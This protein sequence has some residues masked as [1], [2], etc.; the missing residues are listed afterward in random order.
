MEAVV[1]SRVSLKVS[2]VDSLDKLLRYL[3]DL[4]LTTWRDERERERETG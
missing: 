1:N 4:L 2:I 3:D